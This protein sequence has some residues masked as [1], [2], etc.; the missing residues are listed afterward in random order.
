MKPLRM[1]VLMILVMM[2]MVLPFATSAHADSF[3]S[4]EDLA[5]YLCQYVV[6]C[7]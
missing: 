3:D 7:G 5:H 4:A 1:R 6:T 2:L